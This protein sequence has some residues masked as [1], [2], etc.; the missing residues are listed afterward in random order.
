MESYY[1]RF[2]PIFGSWYLKER[3]GKGSTGEV[4][5]I[6]REDMGTTYRS[7]LKCIT[8]PG[9]DDE[10]DTI[11]SNGMTDEEVEKYYQALLDKVSAELNA[12]YALK[13]NSNIVNYEDHVII[14]HE[15]GLGWDILIR[16]ELLTPLLSPFKLMPL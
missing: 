12:L 11:K 7:A 8:I 16:L 13:G 2:E 3:I 14:P 4:Y 1:S 10:I 5:L 9:S 6:E 15:E